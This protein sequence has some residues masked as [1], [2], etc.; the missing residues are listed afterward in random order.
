MEWDAESQ[1][2]EIA[3]AA[4]P[5]DNNDHIP[6]WITQDEPNVFWNLES[7]YEYTIIMYDFDAPNPP[8]LHWIATNITSE[9]RGQD[10]VPYTPPRPPG[11]QIH[12]YTVEVFLQQH[13]I[14]FETITNR[15]EF[16]LDEFIIGNDLVSIWST[17]FL[18]GF[19]PDGYRTS[20]LM[21]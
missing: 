11:N 21:H 9:S 5:I 6:I 14:E 19:L 12:T 2:V 10:L 1:S 18:T 16:P 15:A 4:T 8:Y 7:G 3:F 17:N 13:P 20:Q